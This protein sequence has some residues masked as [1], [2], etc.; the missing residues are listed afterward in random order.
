M[1]V[2]YDLVSGHLIWVG[3]G[4]KTE[5]LALFFEQLSE[6]TSKHYQWIWGKLTIISKGNA[7]PC[8]HCF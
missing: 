2:V 6:Q 5:A 3:H 8:R 4:R 7:T 1:T